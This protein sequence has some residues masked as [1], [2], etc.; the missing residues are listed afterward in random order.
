MHCPSDGL[1]VSG[2]APKIFSRTTRSDLP[3]VA[4]G[5]SSCFAFLAYLMVKSGSNEVFTWLSGF[6][7]TSALITWFG[8]GVI[9]LRF[10]KGMK[11]QGIDRQTLPFMPRVQPFVAWWCVC[12]TA[13]VLFVRVSHFHV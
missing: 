3:Y 11:V 13:F 10:Y 6:C 7:A 9:Y 12:G 4:V 1:A 5:L 2:S 8:I